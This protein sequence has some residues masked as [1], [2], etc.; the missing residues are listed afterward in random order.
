MQF[1]KDQMFHIYNQG[2]NRRQIFFTE[3]NYQYFLWRMRG[4]LLPFG[5]LISWCLMPNHFHWQFFVRETTTKRVHLRNHLDTIEYQ[6]RV[7]KCGVN[8]KPVNKARG[9]AENNHSLI[10]LNNAIGDLLKGYTKAINKEKGWTG[11]LFRGQCKSKDGWID[12]FVSVKNNEKPDW[13]FLIGTDYGCRL[14]WYIHENPVKAKIVEKA[15]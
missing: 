2:N 7:L 11:S 1:Y 12:E 4:Y 5:E 13:R 6:R 15:I 14:M 10:T 9:R 3:D 8:A